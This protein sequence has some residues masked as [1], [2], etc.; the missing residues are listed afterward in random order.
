M[1]E[2]AIIFSLIL[3]AKKRLR[4]H[5][6]VMKWNERTNGQIKSFLALC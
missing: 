3:F 6:F 4:L 5:R 2:I 1:K